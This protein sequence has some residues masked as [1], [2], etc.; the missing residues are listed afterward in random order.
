MDH[1]TEQL[2]ALRAVV[3][4]STYDDDYWICCDNCGIVLQGVLSAHDVAVTA[5]VHDWHVN[6]WT[7]WTTC[8]DCTVPA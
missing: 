2:N 4:Y 3:E 7:A 5:L 6:T 1:T 8:A